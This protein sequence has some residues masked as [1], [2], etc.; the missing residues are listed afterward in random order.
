[1]HDAIDGHSDVDSDEQVYEITS[2]WA[3]WPNKKK[4]GYEYKVIW[5]GFLLHESSY[6][7]EQ[8]ITNSLIKKYDQACPRGSC[9]TN[10]PANIKRYIVANPKAVK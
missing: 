3:R 10:L 9:Y 7:L 2:V 1:M 4:N 8:N 5:K 6:E